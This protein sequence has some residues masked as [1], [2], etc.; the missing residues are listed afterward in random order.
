MK[1]FIFLFVLFCYT[2]IK[3]SAQGFSIDD[4]NFSASYKL[5]NDGKEVE[6]SL[7]IQF[8]GTYSFTIPQEV[9]YMNRNY[10][11][12]GIGERAFE[13]NQTLTSISIPNS[14][15][16][17]GKLAFRHC[18]KV[19]SFTIP[20]SVKSIGIFAFSQ[21]ESLES[22]TTPNSIT[23]LE[24]GT[25]S[26]CGCLTTVNLPNSLTSMGE[27][28]FSGCWQLSSISIPNS[29][30]DIGRMAFY[31]CNS[32]KSITLPSSLKNIGENAFV[33]CGLETIYSLNPEPPSISYSKCFDEHVM[34]FATLYVPKG[35]KEKYKSTPGW[36]FTNIEESETS[37]INDIKLNH[38]NNFHIYNLNGKLLEHIQKGVNIVN[39]KKIRIK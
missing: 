3:V 39:G 27:E 36:S 17:I 19:S 33:D 23:S 12:T 15:T 24:H 4:D 30:N 13:Y 10:K 35:T 5:I 31:R 22:I 34:A 25:F 11:V 29:V 16:Y 7:V 26:S 8:G 6:L 32:L 14:I 18:N 38:K 20:S 2:G 21:C 9:T 28:A 37:N 1:H